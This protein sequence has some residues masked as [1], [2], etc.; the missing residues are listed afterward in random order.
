VVG[1]IVL[2][3]DRLFRNRLP[4]VVALLAGIG[5]GPAVVLLAWLAFR[6]S[7]ETFSGL[8]RFWWRVP[9]EFVVGVVPG[10]AAGAFF[11]VWLTRKQRRLGQP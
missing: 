7:G 10:A 4:A 6:E 8:L 2:G 11:S 3:A 5:A 1:P 9:G